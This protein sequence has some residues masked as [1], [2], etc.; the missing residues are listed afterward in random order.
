MRGDVPARSLL[1]SLHGVSPLPVGDSDDRGSVPPELIRV[2]CGTLRGTLL[3]GCRV[4]E[5]KILC[6]GKEITP[7]EFERLGGRANTKKWKKSIHV[8]LEG[9]AGP[10]GAS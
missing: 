4:R 3:P 5:E 6:D 7:A 1:S 2:T 8:V 9:R 10:F